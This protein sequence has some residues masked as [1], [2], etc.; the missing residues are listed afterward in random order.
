[1]S[2]YFKDFCLDNG[3]SKLIF[4]RLPNNSNFYLLKINNLINVD[5]I[6]S[7]IDMGSKC[8]CCGVNI[9]VVLP[10]PLF[11]KNINIP[12]PDDFYWTDIQFGSSHNRTNTIVVGKDTWSKIKEKKFKKIDKMDLFYPVQK[13]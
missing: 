5:K 1:V 6:R 11:F 3:Y 13:S 8:N 12:L 4:M 2:Q 9:S 10:N 7:G